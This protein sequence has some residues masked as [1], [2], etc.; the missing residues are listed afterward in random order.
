MRLG[1]VSSHPAADALPV[2]YT[3]K[4][5]VARRL[6]VSQAF[7]VET[8]AFAVGYESPSQFSREYTRL[9]GTSP[10]RGL[11]G[12]QTAR[13]AET[14]PEDGKAITRNAASARI[15]GVAN[16]SVAH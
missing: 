12:F 13:H 10:K 11:K 5:Q 16:G 14:A 2:A 9:F 15:R 3:D 8:A 1:Q 4:D 7:N 6:M